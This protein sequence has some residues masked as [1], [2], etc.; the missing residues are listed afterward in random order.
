MKEHIAIFGQFDVTTSRNQPEIDKNMMMSYTQSVTVTRALRVH[1][2]IWKTLEGE[3]FRLWHK[4][5]YP[6]K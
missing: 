3:G 5:K 4:N 6:S 2:E 1:I